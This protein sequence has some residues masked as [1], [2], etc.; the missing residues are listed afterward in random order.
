MGHFSNSFWSI[1]FRYVGKRVLYVY[2]AHKKTRVH[3]KAPSRLRAIWGRITRVHGNAGTVKA[4]FRR[5]LPPQAMGKRVRVVRLRLMLVQ[6]YNTSE[7]SCCVK[8]TIFG[9]NVLFWIIG[10]AL[11][12]VGVWAHFEKNSAYSHLNKASRFYLDPAIFL[13]FAGGLIFLIGFS[14]CVGALRENT[15]FLA[16]YSTIIGLLLLAEMALI[17][18]VFASKDWIT[19]EFFTRL[20]DTVIMYR[21]DPDLQA[22]IDWVQIYFKCCGMRSPN[23]WDMNIYFNKSSQQFS[24]PEAG[25]VPYSC[26]K[27]MRGLDGGPINFFCGHGARLFK[28]GL[29]DTIHSEGCTPKIENYLSQNMTYVA[30]AVVL[31]AVIQILGI[32]FAQNLRSDIFAQRARWYTGR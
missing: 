2:K 11:L 20:D 24:S 22:L 10:F 14:G 8:Y 23:D 15:C 31:V 1:I 13:I 17:V 12:A 28:E 32:L 29:S 5:N 4:K 3:G 26:C 6:H 16:L 25:G 21:D 18:L 30:I 7:I 19:Q 27:K 9:F